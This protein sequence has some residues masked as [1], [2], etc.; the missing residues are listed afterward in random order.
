MQCQIVKNLKVFYMSYPA[1]GD[2]PGLT[3]IQGATGLQGVTGVGST[4]ASVNTFVINADQL[5][6]PNSSDW[7]V[8]ALAPAAS[9][10]NNSGISVRLFDDTVEEGVG[11][12]LTIPASS[13]NLTLRLKSRAETAPGSAETVA[14]TLYYRH[15][16]DNS[17]V[18][19]WTSTNL[20]NINIPTNE[21]FQY[22]NELF[23][24]STLSIT[25]GDYYQFELTR[26]TG[27]ASDTLTGDWVL[28]E[29]VLEF[30]Q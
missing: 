6:N 10:T 21:N 7:A 27:S 18:G 12:G 19:S 22:D 11:F 29:I 26:N 24:L 14:L 25:A 2:S 1:I 20:S 15:I 28:L 8:N 5:D 13:N 3:G 16:P 30:E 17:S 9:D 23:S 4:S